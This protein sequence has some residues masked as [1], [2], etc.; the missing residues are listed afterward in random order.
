MM[1][2]PATTEWRN[3][4]ALYFRFEKNNAL[5]DENHNHSVNKLRII[6]IS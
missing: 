5:Q 4:L 1:W 6:H 2:A 3:T